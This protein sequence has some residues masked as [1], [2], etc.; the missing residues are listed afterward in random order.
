MRDDLPD[1][2][3]EDEMTI[4]DTYEDCVDLLAKLIA[5]DIREKEAMGIETGAVFLEE[6]DARRNKR[7]AS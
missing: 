6:D 5:E 4:P 3:P 1:S 2:Y 7:K